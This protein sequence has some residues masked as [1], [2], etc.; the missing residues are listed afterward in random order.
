MKRLSLI[1]LLWYIVIRKSIC[2]AFRFIGSG[3]SGQW[4]KTTVV[5][6]V[7]FMDSLLL[8]SWLV[9]SF[10]GYLRFQ[11]SHLQDMPYEDWLRPRVKKF[12]VNNFV[13]ILRIRETLFISIT[14]TTDT[15]PSNTWKGPK[16]ITIPYHTCT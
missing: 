6:S 15:F 12:W 14:C 5:V 11:D 16:S 9:R 8:E 13:K 3:R 2:N 7:I 1:I 4:M 10:D